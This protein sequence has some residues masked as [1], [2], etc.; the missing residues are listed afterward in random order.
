VAST[1]YPSAEAYLARLPAGIDS[2]P[3]CQAKG[4]LLRLILEAHSLEPPDGSLPGSV[5]QMIKAPPPVSSW[6][7]EVAFTS[8]LLAVY[9]DAFGGTDLDGFDAWVYGLNVELFTKPL[10][11][12][13][14]A[15][16]APQRLVGMATSRWSAFHRGSTLSLIGRGPR[17]AVVRLEFPPDLFGPQ[18]IRTVSA[19][20]R[21]AI[22]TSGA[23]EPRSRVE[24][25]AST[26][27]ECSIDW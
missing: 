12:I 11:R 17:R 16:I 21:A 14:F 10:Y 6:I 9:D 15:F 23:S 24:A 4:S 19:G 1:T 22:L 13:L 7:S 20:I 8:A 2:Y 27:A 26:S 25:I 18:S 3:A 5:I